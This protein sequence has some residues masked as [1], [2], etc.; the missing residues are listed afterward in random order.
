M[1]I[2]TWNVNGL[3]AIQ[4]K[5]FEDIMAVL[6]PDI[7][8]LQETKAQASQIEVDEELFPY[9]YVNCAQR[10][11][12]SGTMI[13]SL[14]EPAAVTNGINSFEHDTEGR[15]LTAEFDHFYL[16][17]VYVPN[18]G[19]N[20][21]RLDYRM[22]WDKAFSAYLKGLEEKKPILVCGDFNIARTALDV[23]DE[24]AVSQFAGYT[25]Q[26]RESFETAFMSWLKDAFRELHPDTRKYTWWS[27]YSRGRDNDQGERIDY[28]LA[29]PQLMDK[30]KDV[31]IL[32]DVFGSDHCPVEIDIDL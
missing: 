27:Y 16:V 32:T 10:K 20:L 4:K 31:T 17:D 24:Q 23:Y 15:V 28:W 11:G 30:I 12:Y 2:I 7:V 25:L 21:K 22:E 14:T 13:L 19:E 26:E 9:Q 18:S 3:R 5:G 29:S 6:D 8:C 1:R